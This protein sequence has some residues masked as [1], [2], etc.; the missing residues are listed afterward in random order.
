VDQG[1]K[2]NGGGAR[3]LNIRTPF[4]LYGM[5]NSGNRIGAA[6]LQATTS[7]REPVRLAMDGQPPNA[8]NCFN[9][10]AGQVFNMSIQLIARGMRVPGRWFAWTLPLGVLSAPNGPASLR[11]D[12][13]TPAIL[14]GAHATGAR[15]KAQ[16]DTEHGCLSLTFTPPAESDERWEITAHVEFAAAL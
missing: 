9:P 15:V 16:A 1:A 6:A 14:S 11:W 10:G 8:Y 4:G 5:P 13:G 12:E 7:G 2:S 3:S